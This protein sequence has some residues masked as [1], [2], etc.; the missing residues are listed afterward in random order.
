MGCSPHY[1][2]CIKSNDSKQALTIDFKRV[3]HQVKYLGLAENIKVRRAGYAYRAEY[4]R[5]IDRFAM[6]DDLNRIQNLNGSDKDICKELLKAIS[7]K[8]PGNVLAKDEAQFGRTM[9][10]I[11]TPE[12]Y[13][14]IEQLREQIINEKV[15]KIQS[16]W[17]TYCQRRVFIQLQITISKLFKENNKMR[18]RESFMRPYYGDYLTSL[19]L[20]S[21][22]SASG[23]RDKTQA[24]AIQAGVSRIIHFYNK[25]EQILFA[26]INC[27]QVIASSKASP[28]WKYSQ[29]MLVLTDA[30]IYLM[31]YLSTPA[32]KKV[33]HSTK[34]AVIPDVILRRRISIEERSQPHM[35]VLESYSLTTLSDATLALLVKPMTRLNEPY[36]SPR[37]PEK[38]SAK[39][40]SVTG[41]SFTMFEW[42]KRCKVTG[43]IMIDAVCDY[44][45]SL[46]DTGYYTPDRCGDQS[47][48]LVSTDQAEDT[49]SLRQTHRVH[50]ATE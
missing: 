25:N 48:G 6:I 8:L 44:E 16:T 15:I 47:I 3:Q 42:K 33:I 39:V 7:K 13:F 5:F 31:E 2:R 50:S 27:F 37:W 1:V 34:A 26:D 43:D 22:L 21:S 29:R 12:T 36:R 49:T 18:R 35:A 45:Q 11:R 32:M 19:S 10:F 14:L 41:K 4:H 17:K 23:I 40:C 24:K 28:S 20:S 38:Q 9:I 30:A 46:P